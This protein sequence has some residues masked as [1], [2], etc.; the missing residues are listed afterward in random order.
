MKIIT[1]NCNMAFRKKAQ[2]ILAEK[3]DILIV[4]ECENLSKLQ[5][6]ED[7]PIPT[8]TL[9]YGANPNKGL[10]I[11]SYSNYKFKLLKCHNPDFK[12]ILPIA[13]TGGK[14]N[15]TLFAIWANNPADK[16]GAYVTQVWKA[17]HYYEELLSKSKVILIGDFNSNSI[18]DRPRRVG[19]HSTVVEKLATNKIFST[20]H[21]FHQQEQ[22]K[23]AHPTQFMYRHEDKPYHL[24]YCFAS[25]YFIK[26]IKDVKIGQYQDWKL[27]SD[28]KPLSVT[29]DL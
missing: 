9:W 7:V 24:D 19:N 18:W 14:V 8:S 5:F 29:F 10:G 17:L 15:F 16:D 23:E 28:H 12:N 6:P 20:Y 13:V 21:T 2:F 22:G 25:S 11:F 4:P 26:R 27:Y 1:W 3:P